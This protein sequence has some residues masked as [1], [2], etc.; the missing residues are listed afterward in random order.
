MGEW[1]SEVRYTRTQRPIYWPRKTAFCC[2][3]TQHQQHFITEVVS[4]EIATYDSD[5]Y[6]TNCSVQRES[7]IKIVNYYGSPLICAAQ[8]GHL[9]CLQ[10]HMEDTKDVSMLGT[11][12][13]R[14][15]TVL[16]AAAS[17]RHKDVVEYLLYY[18]A[19]INAR[20]GQGS[21][22][23]H[24]AA[25]FGYVDVVQ[26][27]LEKGAFVNL[28]NDKGETALFLAVSE[29]HMDGVRWLLES[30]VDYY[31]YRGC[32]YN[33]A[34][35]PKEAVMLLQERK[36]D[37][38][39][40]D[41]SV[42]GSLRLALLQGDLARIRF[43]LK[44]E[45]VVCVPGFEPSN[46]RRLSMIKMLLEKGAD[47]EIK[48]TH[49]LSVLDQ[50]V[51]NKDI[52]CSQ[53]LLQFG[54]K[55]NSH[56]NVFG[57]TMT[58]LHLASSCYGCE[59]ITKILLDAGCVV[60]CLDN[61]K[62]TPLHIAVNNGSL[63][64]VQLLL[65]NGADVHVKDA[66]GNTPLH[67]VHSLDFAKLLVDCGA[68][69]KAVTN[70]GKTVIFS[71]A[72]KQGDGECVRFLISRG[73]DPLIRDE[74]GTSALDIAIQ[75]HYNSEQWF[76]DDG[77]MKCIGVLLENGAKLDAASIQDEYLHNAI[78]RRRLGYALALLYHGVPVDV[79]SVKDKKTAL[80]LATERNFVAGMKLL[81]ERG[82]D[83]N[84]MVRNKTALDIAIAKGY[85]DC[86]RIL[87]QAGCHTST[88]IKDVIKMQNVL[89]SRLQLL[90]RL[91]PG[92]INVQD[93]NGVALIHMLCQKSEHEGCMETLLESGV[94]ANIM[95]KDGVTC[96]HIL[97]Y[98]THAMCLAYAR[99]LLNRGADINKQDCNGMTP[100]H[101][102]AC[103]GHVKFARL[104]L[105]YGAD[106]NLQD[107]SGR[108]ALHLAAEHCGNNC[109]LVKLFL[110]HGSAV[111]ARNNEGWTPLHETANR[112]HLECMEQLVGYGADVN[113]LTDDGISALHI[114]EL[115]KHRDCVTW[116]LDIGAHRYNATFQWTLKHYLGMQHNTTYNL[117]WLFRQKNE[118]FTSA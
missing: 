48:D 5:E 21:T 32:H 33:P 29:G 3:A 76:F 84:I 75:R 71:A 100:L 117:Q 107:S 99:W 9:Q 65:E 74:S 42:L 104:L 64:Q 1:T 108:T 16:H 80:Y 86:A 25:K 95:D 82:A 51:L 17:G 81:L 91:Y 10:K 58:P 109:S 67:N 2:M 43:I 78:I 118:A 35:Y 23:L 7:H 31:D 34:L 24:D 20:R 36:T 30:V 53:L 106:P 105:A 85:E 54:A 88:S 50:A 18:G 89:L 92:D 96:L 98:K 94:D 26:L 12:S 83:P 110:H 69:V 77:G 90:V 79:P 4:A 72:D 73:V 38:N 112:G 62:R 101:Y 14:S 39:K 116:L 102:T 11:W 113:A 27:L 13:S 66:K 63:K 47:T 28:Q 57:V 40:M 93:E 70:S 6:E 37:I 111:D 41:I 97:A 19:D 46:R 61:E 45:I 44:E 87:I 55:V 52:L 8:K 22:A 60:N 59:E 49:G 15:T 103:S 115:Q 56:S 68:D 114:A